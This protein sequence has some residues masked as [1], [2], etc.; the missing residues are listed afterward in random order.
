M[1]PKHIILIFIVL[2]LMAMFSS[3]AVIAPQYNNTGQKRVK[4]YDCPP[5]HEGRRKDKNLRY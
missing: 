1:R 2:G 3:C 5:K 4:G